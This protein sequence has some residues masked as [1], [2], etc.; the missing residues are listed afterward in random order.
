MS[1][2]MYLMEEVKRKILVQL[3]EEHNQQMEK[4]VGVEFALGT[5]KRYH[6]TKSHVAE[7][8]KAEYRKNDIPVKDVDL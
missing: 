7:Y 4:L 2:D 8:V 3:F 6:T 5:W 1:G